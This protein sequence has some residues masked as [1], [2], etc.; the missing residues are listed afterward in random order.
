VYTSAGRTDEAKPIIA[1]LAVAPKTSP[2]FVALLHLMI[3][4]MDAVYTWLDRGVEERSDMM[5]TLRTNPFFVSQW[6]NPRFAAVLQR[7]GLGEPLSAF[8]S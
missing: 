2:F 4:D 7:I 8:P 3:G 5:H 6:G 1:E